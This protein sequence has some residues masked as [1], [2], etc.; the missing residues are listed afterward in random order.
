[1]LWGLSFNAVPIGA[2]GLQAHFEGE[3]D[4][5]TVKHRL[6][7][8]RELQRPIYITDFRISGLAPAQ[9][10]AGQ[11]TLAYSSRP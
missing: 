10:A 8:L 7:V 3:V 1:M 4:A 2:I 11:C 9:Q 6:D 5:S